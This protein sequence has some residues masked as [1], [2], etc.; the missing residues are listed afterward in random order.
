MAICFV[1]EELGQRLRGQKETGL[2]R[3]RD[4]LVRAVDENQRDAFAS[5]LERLIE[6]RNDK[7]HQG[8][9]ARKAVNHAVFVGTVLENGL[10]ANMVTVDDLMVEGVLFAEPFMTLAKVRELMLSHS[11]SFLPVQLPDAYALIPD[12]EV[13]KLRRTSTGDGWKRLQGQTVK[14][15]LE[16]GVLSTVP[17]KVVHTGTLLNACKESLSAEPWLIQ[18]DVGHIIGILSAFDWL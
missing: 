18:N 4:A 1:L 12:F 15:L 5:R 11:F 14:Q 17:A 6:A 10:V 9:S 3:Y 2:G 13:A 16:A 8:V 7:A